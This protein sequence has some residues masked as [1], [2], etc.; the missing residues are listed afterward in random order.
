MDPVADLLAVAVNGECLARQGARQHE[1]QKFFRVLS[2][3]VVVGASHRDDGQAVGSEVGASELIGRR[4]A[5]G[6]RTAW[7]EG[8]GLR[9]GRRVRGHGAVDLVGG[10]VDE[11]KGGLLLIGERQPVAVCNTQKNRRSPDVRVD[12]HLRA[13]N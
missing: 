12:E 10:D 7:I 1:G 2:G 6:V 4:L 8:R 9:V 5:R 3:T 13:G 11:A